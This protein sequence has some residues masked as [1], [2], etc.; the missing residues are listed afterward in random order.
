MIDQFTK[1]MIREVVLRRELLNISQREMAEYI[2]IS[3]YHLDQIERMLVAMDFQY[4]LRYCERLGIDFTVKENKMT[5]NN[6][7][8]LAMRTNDQMADHRLNKELLKHTW[9]EDI[10]V[11]GIL[12]G[13]LGLTGESGEFADVIKKWIFHEKP[14]DMDHAKKE[15]GDVLWYV[16]MICESFNWSME[17]I[18][19]LNIDKLIARYPEGFDTDKANNRKAGDI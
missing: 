10:K 1:D 15:L 4:F 5:G 12:N 13:V 17:E 16:A 19:S 8:K 14:L 18:M 2:G 6:Y 7:Q 3:V 9:P 11:G